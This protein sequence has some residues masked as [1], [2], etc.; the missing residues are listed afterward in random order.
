MTGRPRFH[1]R[2][3]SFDER[4]TSWCVKKKK[5]FRGR[6][7]CARETCA[8]ETCANIDT[9]NEINRGDMCFHFFQITTNLA[10]G[11]PARDGKGDLRQGGRA[12]RETC[13]GD[14]RR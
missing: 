7:T 3:T 4:E 8:M 11:R 2:E 9:T 6:E 5:K 12:D 13:A 1:E 10:T 14:L